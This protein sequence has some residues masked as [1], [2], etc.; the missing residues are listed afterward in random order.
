MDTAKNN[1]LV[2][3]GLGEAEVREL[4]MGKGIQGLM[5][6]AGYV[7]GVYCGELVGGLTWRVEPVGGIECL[8]DAPN[9]ILYRTRIVAEF[10]ICYSCRHKL[11]RFFNPAHDTYLFVRGELEYQGICELCQYREEIPF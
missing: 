4:L 5:N 2:N 8:R 3:G 6:D 9:V 1:M 10:P 11:Q 7:A